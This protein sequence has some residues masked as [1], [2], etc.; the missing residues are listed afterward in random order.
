V[1]IAFIPLEL[2]ATELAHPEATHTVVVDENEELWKA[3]N[4]G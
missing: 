3:C 4:D 2:S 1:G